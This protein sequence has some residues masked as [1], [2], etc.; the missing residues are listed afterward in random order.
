MNI[1]KDAVVDSLRLTSSEGLTEY[2][3]LLC[4]QRLHPEA[5]AKQSISVYAKKL[6]PAK[7]GLTRVELNELLILLGQNRVD[8]GFFSFF[9]GEGTLTREKLLQGLKRFRLYALLMHGNFRKPFQLW[10][11]YEDPGGKQNAG[12]SVE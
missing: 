11:K 1:R 4:G 12:S 7:G 2:L 10:R 8:S 3:A 5:R 6:R 9:Y